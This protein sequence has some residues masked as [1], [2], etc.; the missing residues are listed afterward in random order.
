M[1]HYGVGVT[2]IICLG[3]SFWLTERVEGI[4]SFLSQ[5]KTFLRC[6]LYDTS[7]SLGWRELPWCLTETMVAHSQ[8]VGC[9]SFCFTVSCLPFLFSLLTSLTP[10]AQKPL[11]QLLLSRAFQTHTKA[12]K[13]EKERVWIRWKRCRF[14]TLLKNLSNLRQNLRRWKWN[15]V[16]N[17]KP[18]I[19]S[20]RQNYF[21]N[22]KKFTSSFY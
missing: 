4:W 17:Q 13:L 20:K 11:S 1:P 8:R 15:G 10:S 14:F 21:V 12:Y 22:E 9:P 3:G 19:Q 18:L 5:K 7:K 6:V 2:L 16:T